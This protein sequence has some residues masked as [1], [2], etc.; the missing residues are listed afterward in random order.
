MNFFP[1]IPP[2]NYLAV[3]FIIF[4]NRK[5][6]GGKRFHKFPRVI[7]SWKTRDTTP[8]GPRPP[9]PPPPPL[10]PLNPAL[11]SSFVE[12]KASSLESAARGVEGVG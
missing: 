5:K 10:T 4:E 9:L 1:R 8:R 7:I 3:N 11:P 2:P 12:M 6:R